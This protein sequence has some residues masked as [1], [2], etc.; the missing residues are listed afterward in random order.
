M[1]IHGIAAS[2]GVAV[3]F[4]RR[5][6]RAPAGHRTDSMC[7]DESTALDSLSHGMLLQHLQRRIEILI[8]QYNA[9]A[10]LHDSPQPRTLRE[11]WNDLWPQEGSTAATLH[12]IGGDLPSCGNHSQECPEDDLSPDSS[13]KPGVPPSSTSLDGLGISAHDVEV[14]AH[15][16]GFIAIAESMTAADLRRICREGA[17]GVILERCR[18]HSDTMLLARALGIPLVCGLDTGIE[19]ITDNRSVVV[20]GTRGVVQLSDSCDPNLGSPL[21]PDDLANQPEEPDSVL[22]VTRD[23]VTIRVLLTL[24]VTPSATPPLL[25]VADGI[26]L[27]RSSRVDWLN[28]PPTVADFLKIYRHEAELLLEQEL[29]IAL[30]GQGTFSGQSLHPSRDADAPTSQPDTAF[31]QQHRTESSLR[32]WTV[33]QVQAISQL[34]KEHTVTLLLPD[35]TSRANLESQIAALFDMVN[36]ADRKTLPFRIGVFIESP[37]TALTAREWLPLAQ[38]LTIDWD[39][40]ARNMAGLEDWQTPVDPVTLCLAPPVL[41]LLQELAELARDRAIPLTLCAHLLGT[42]ELVAVALALGIRRLSVSPWSFRS[43]QQIIS[44]FSIQG[45]GELR[46]LLCSQA[47]ELEVTQWLSEKLVK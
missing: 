1:M 15:T 47:S 46:H 16:G 30:C 14:H 8:R 28:T 44:Q 21:F 41:R 27:W 20:D 13:R 42:P 22:A 9:T 5:V 43:C 6:D 33:P 19:M 24:D 26:G 39:S 12:E 29:Q 38:S 34:A 11:L 45:L 40:L 31:Y 36:G 25:A 7:P 23:G 10:H 4:A 3:G 18:W 35:I 37:S 2:P 17:V 32:D